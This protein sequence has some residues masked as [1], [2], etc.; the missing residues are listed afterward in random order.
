MER[1]IIFAGFGGQGILFAGHVLAQAAMTEGAQVLWIP[2]YGPEM[3]G[4]TASC[5]VLIG[6]ETIGSPIVDHPDA[7][8]VF[9]P[10][11]LAKFAPIVAAG[12]V[13][14]VNDSLIEAV[15]GR[16]DVD[17]VRVKCTALA[18]EAGDDRLINVVALGA[19]VA[20]TRLVRPESIRDALR[21]IVGKKRPQALEID[22]RAFD[23]GLAA[24]SGAG[25]APEPATA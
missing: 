3:R 16:D 12:G 22:L 1:S 4:G 15:S 13:L 20:R 24:A 5:T 7:A 2:S 8:V 10:P 25:A 18:R 21:E 17:E 6:D 9:N 23:L 14:V 19:L 11:S